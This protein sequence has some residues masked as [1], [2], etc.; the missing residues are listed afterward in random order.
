MTKTETLTD[1]DTYVYT[2]RDS[3]YINLGNNCTLTC[4]FCPKHNGT[5]MVH[6]YDMSLEKPPTATMVI[7]AI[8]DPK[9]YNEIVFCGYGEPTLRLKPLLEIATWVKAKG[10]RVRVNT[11]GLGNLANKRNILPELSKCVDALSISLNAQDEETYNLHC[12]PGLKGSWEAMLAFS[13]E[14]TK[15]IDEVSVSAINGLEGVDIPKCKQLAEKMG[16]HFKERFM[17]VVG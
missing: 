2:I 3:L 17:D 11:D 8:N 4:D 13:Q 1:H 10:G 6:D 9:Q 12:K 16:V 14:A 15:W 7:D 5:W